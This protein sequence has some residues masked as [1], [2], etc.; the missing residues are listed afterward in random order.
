MENFSRSGNRML[1]I[2]DEVT[3]S[4]HQEGG[5]KCA[6]NGNS[7]IPSFDPGDLPGVGCGI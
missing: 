2:L 7:N 3:G 5:S 6:T 4:E 1:G